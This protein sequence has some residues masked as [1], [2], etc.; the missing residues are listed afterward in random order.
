MESGQRVTSLPITPSPPAAREAPNTARDVASFVGEVVAKVMS[1]ADALNLGLAKS[2]YAIVQALPKFPAA[3]LF[4]DLVFGW[5][6]AH[7]HPP[8]LIPPIPPI[9]L[10]SIGPVIC[11]GAVSV[12]INGMPSARC[13]DVGFGV[14]CGGFFPLFEVQTGSSH[15]FIGG[16]RPAR[17]LIDFT[18][19]CVPGVPGLGKLGAAMMAFSAGM[20]GLQIASS[21]TDMANADAAADSAESAAEAAAASASASAAAVGAGVAALQ[22][23]ADLA[24]AALQAG[25]GKDP[26]IPPGIP[27]GNFLTGSPNVLIGGFPMPGWMAV[28]RGLARLLQKGVGRSARPWAQRLNQGLCHFTGHPVDIATGR[29]VTSTT[30]FKL[31]GRIPI[32]FDRAYDT[33]AVDYTGSLGSGWIH[34]YD[35]H[36]W[37][38]AEQN[39]VS[40]RDEELNVVYFDPVEVGQ[41]SFNTMTRTWLERTGEYNYLMRRNNGLRYSFSAVESPGEIPSEL[42]FSESAALRLASIEDR[43]DNR[44]SLRYEQGLLRAVETSAQDRILFNYIELPD[45]RI[46]LA[47]IRR[48][49]DQLSGQ[50]AHLVRY[51]YDDEGRLT[52]ATD[53]GLVPW[54]Y[55]YSN[56]LL[57]RE[58]NRNGLSFHFAYDGEGP[59]ARCIHTWGDRGVYER[60]LTYDSQNRVTILE[61]SFHQKT[62][63]YFD[64]R[65]LLISMVDALGGIKRFS[66]SPEGYLLEESDE[67]A[68]IT[69]YGYNRFGDRVSVTHPDGTTQYFTYTQDHLL[70]TSI[71]E[72][73]APFTRE[74]DERGNLIAVENAQGG[75]HEFKF[76]PFGDLIE[77]RDPFGVAAKFAWNA[78]GQIVSYTTPKGSI[79]RY[80]VDD[81]GRLSRLSDPLGRSTRF[82]YD[83]SNRLSQVESPDGAKQHYEYDPEGNLTAVKDAYGRQTQFRYVDANKLGAR[84]DPSGAMRQFLYDTEAN[85]IEVRNE[86]EEAYKFSFDALNRIASEVGFDASTWRFQ[87]NAAG[88]LLS[89]TDPA[90]RVTHFLRDLRGQTIE[91]RR[92]DGATIRFEYDPAGQLMAA[93]SPESALKFQY[94][95]LGQLISESQDGAVVEHEYDAL[96][97]RLKRRSPAGATV[98]FSYD[99]DHSLVRM[100]TPR[101]AVEYEYDIAGQLSA[102]RLPGDLTESYF[103][104]RCGRIIEQSL[105]QRGALLFHHGYGYDAEGYLT[106]FSSEKETLQYKYDPAGRLQETSYPEKGIER[107]AYDSTGNLLRRGNQVFRY[108]KPDRLTRTDQATLIY[109][110]LGNLIEKRRADSAIR[111]SYDSD[112]RLTTVD[113]IL[114]GRIEFKYDAFGRRISKTSKNGETRFLWDGDV[115]LAESEPAGSQ[116]YLFEPDSHVPVC[117]FDEHGFESYHT[118]YL[119][120]PRMMTDEAGAV[121]WSA[122]YDVYGRLDRIAKNQN[123]S[124][125]RFQGQYEDETGLFYNAHRYY[126]PELCRYLTKDPLRLMGGLNPY[127]YVDP[128]TMFVDPLG[129]LP[130]AWNPDDGMGHHLV[131]RGKANS[132]GLGLLGTERNTPTFFP[133]P[134]E[135]GMHEQL[136]RA[137]RPHIGRLQGPWEGTPA[138]LIAAS[139]KGL[140]GL[141]MRGNLKIPSTGKIIARNVTPAEAFDRLMRWHNQQLKAQ[142]GC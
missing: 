109:D 80:E 49:L 125:L 97:R 115:L 83:A 16:A 134:Y 58:T 117:R 100:Q 11:A 60:R 56:R 36:L 127:S 5:P 9:P 67:L 41:K 26:A 7:A 82:T 108:E 79:T 12:L 72:L 40:F 77:T 114:H 57:I 123:Q 76:N 101:G 142:G 112:N 85:L 89:Q 50:T 78:R 13:G 32:E 118:D 139:R 126:D 86:R 2:T 88:E 121:A 68:R 69:K 116:E 99:A 19:H 136:H 138:E 20:S 94:D 51:S 61:N 113:S 140:V 124:N 66:Y 119:G 70:Q 48:L 14:W 8:N 55:A 87:Y 128:P 33:A 31:P 103:Y 75:R 135:P 120:T 91:R 23:A 37:F 47:E 90:G 44:V 104:D 130:W 25:M 63:Y 141:D 22:M 107:F 111:Y 84:I 28:L 96:G 46:R 73:G 29:V 27:I 92:P 93:L 62:T 15:V 42:G 45:G 59:E 137:Q 65:D 1:P 24:A 132:V 102:R 131:P 129:L 95:N 133:V 30:D 110:E 98:Q 35:I 64:A 53:R 3:R 105:H 122:S 38:D 10:P 39:V 81:W 71:D 74:Y 106:K 21:L 43:N 6:H 52:N 34:P 18:R 17:M 4:V 54:R